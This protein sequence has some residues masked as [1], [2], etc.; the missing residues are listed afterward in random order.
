MQDT[1]QQKQR[2]TN[3]TDWNEHGWIAHIVKKI[4]ETIVGNARRRSQI[5]SPCTQAISE[6]GIGSK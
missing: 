1:V 5:L 2:S 6:H 4:K 3:R